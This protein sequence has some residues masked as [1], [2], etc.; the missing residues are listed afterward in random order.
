MTAVAEVGCDG[1]G[2]TAGGHGGR[3]DEKGAA[4]SET[5]FLANPPLLSLRKKES[6]HQ[7]VPLSP[8][9]ADE[10]GNGVFGGEADVGVELRIEME[11]VVEHDLDFGPS[12]QPL[13]DQAGRWSHLVQSS[14]ERDRADHQEKRCSHSHPPIRPT[15]GPNHHRPDCGRHDSEGLSVHAKG[16]DGCGC[17]GLCGWGDHCKDDD[18]CVEDGE[19]GGTH[20]RHHHHPLGGHLHHGNRDHQPLC[21]CRRPRHPEGRLGPQPA[22][23]GGNLSPGWVAW[24]GRSW[25]GNGPE[26][27]VADGD[28]AD[29][30][31]A[32]LTALEVRLYLVQTVVSKHHRCLHDC[33]CWGCCWFWS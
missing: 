25:R 29:V 13:D 7:P 32:V 30:S 12:P 27:H 6:I 21:S 5:E 17:D 19:A 8:E 1:D 23:V 26:E 15:G 14:C 4:G 16:A 9:I 31:A 11:G 2:E 3:S 10:D 20:N 33:H 18:G 22:A 28:A 24:C